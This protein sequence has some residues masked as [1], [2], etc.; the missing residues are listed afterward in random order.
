MVRSNSE[1]L[2]LRSSDSRS[3]RLASLRPATANPSMRTNG[4]KSKNKLAEKETGLSERGI[5]ASEDDS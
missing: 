3:R 4:R 2:R 5:I 1:L